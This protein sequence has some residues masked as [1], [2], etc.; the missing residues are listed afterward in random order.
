[1][2]QFICLFNIMA[3]LFNFL[4]S[5]YRYFPAS[6]SCIC[7]YFVSL[8]RLQQLSQTK[9]QTSGNNYIALLS[10]RFN[11]LLLPLKIRLRTILPCRLDIASCENGKIERLPHFRMTFFIPGSYSIQALFVVWV[12]YA[13]HEIHSNLSIATN[14]NIDDVEKLSR[15]RQTLPRTL[16]IHI[17]SAFSTF[18][19]AVGWNGITEWCVYGMNVFEHMNMLKMWFQ[20]CNLAG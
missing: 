12:C 7:Q 19:I 20:N 18:L 3:F 16:F 4:P 6:F 2:K 8:N 1:M 17:R 9:I 13:I 14:S 5:S 10:L 15:C 11:R